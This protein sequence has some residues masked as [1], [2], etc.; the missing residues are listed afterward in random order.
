MQDAR[1]TNATGNPAFIDDNIHCGTEPDLAAMAPSYYKHL[2]LAGLTDKEQKREL[3]PMVGE[4]LGVWFDSIR[5]TLSIPQDKVTRLQAT[6][7]Q[8]IDSK[9]ISL[10]EIMQLLGY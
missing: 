7:Q 9:R 4:V 1:N 6:M 5:M 2:D 8:H 10:T 3:L